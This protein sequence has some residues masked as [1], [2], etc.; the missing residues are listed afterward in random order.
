MKL[1]HPTGLSLTE[2]AA[3]VTT[4]HPL[5]SVSTVDIRGETYR[6]FDAIPE[7]IPAMFRAARPETVTDADNYLVYLEER[8]TYGKFM[9]EAQALTAAMATEFGTGK[10]DRVAI[11]MR[12]YPEMLML[13]VAISSLGASVVLLNAWWTSEELDYAVGD[14]RP[15]VIFADGARGE[16]L[17][18]LQA[19]HN[20]HLVGVRDGEPLGARTYRSLRNAHRGAAWTDVEIAPDDDF[21]IMY[22]SGTTGHPKGVVQTHRGALSAVYTWLMAFAM[23]P[24]MATADAQPEASPFTPCILA[25]TPLFHVTATHPIFLLSIPMGSRLVLLHKWDPEEAVRLIDEEKIT[26]FLGVPTQAAELRAAATRLGSGLES[27][28]YLGSG[29]AKRPPSQVGEQAEAF[30]GV[31]VASGWGMTETN[32]VGLSISGPDYLARPD[33]TG[34]ILPPLQDLAIW[35]D[36]NQPLPVGEL[37]ELVVRSPA[38]MRCY[39]NQ[40]EATAETLVSGWL[41][42]GDLATVDTEGF[43][44]IV[45][46]KKNII[47]RGGENIACL[48]VEGALQRH[49]DVVEAGAFAVPDERLGEVVGVG[50]EVRKGASLSADQLATFLSGHLASFKTPDYFWF[51]DTQL[52]RGAT[53]KTDRRA[54]RVECLADM[55]AAERPA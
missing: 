5:F 41:K 1:D 29:G 24:L 22:S 52:P 35:D 30:P 49:G 36:Y 8:W 44:T 2:A 51:R 16:R 23:G 13:M 27:L 31:A 55:E 25:V 10:D 33:S 42:T 54:L 21:A 38:N 37:G 7:N 28:D 12:N 11:A 17:K 43:V 32:A 46:R 6:V 26:R 4:N 34:R 48:D 19:D 9:A 18:P 40:P 50:I 47:I 14:S 45:D 53:D 39:L 15:S 20:F 3:H